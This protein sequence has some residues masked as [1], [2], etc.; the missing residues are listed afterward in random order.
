MILLGGQPQSIFFRLVA[1]AGLEV[2][3]AVVSAV[4]SAVTVRIVLASLVAVLAVVVASVVL[5]SVEWLLLYS[6]TRGL[7][8]GH[9]REK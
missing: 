9:S 4:V 1:D 6:K 8:W 3:L 7:P 5:P 2:G